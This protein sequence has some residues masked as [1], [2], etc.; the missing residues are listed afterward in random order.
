M[1]L[2]LGGPFEACSA[3]VACAAAPV[4]VGGLLVTEGAIFPAVGFEECPSSFGSHIWGCFFLFG[5]LLLIGVLWC[6]HRMCMGDLSL[7]KGLDTYFGEAQAA[8]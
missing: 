1:L 6:V 7:L 4:C 3:V 2:A 8:A 5:G